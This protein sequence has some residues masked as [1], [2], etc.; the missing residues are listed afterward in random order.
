MT[1][2]C[3]KASWAFI[4]PC[5]ILAI[6]ASP[7]MAG[8][9]DPLDFAAVEQ[10]DPL[11]KPFIGSAQSGN[12][13]VVVGPRG[14]ILFSN[15][16][17][18]NWAQARVP[19]Q[20]DLVAVD[21]ASQSKGWAVGHDGV[22]LATTD[23][24]A[25]WIKQLDG[26]MA[27][28]QFVGYYRK[29]LEQGDSSVEAALELVELN[30]R[31]GPALPFLDV[32]FRDEMTG[33]AVGAFGS[34]VRTDD[35]GQS[36]MPWAHRI[37]NAEGA[38]LNSVV[39]IGEDVFIGSERGTLF[40]LNAELQSFD[41]LETGY[42]GTFTGVTGAGGVI[43]AY[44]LQGTIYRSTDR[45]DSWLE[46]AELPRATINDAF[47]RGGDQGYVLANQSGEL[48]VS[49]KRFAKFEVIDTGVSAN[50]TSVLEV[51]DQ[52]LLVTTLQGLAKVS[53]TDHRM[54]K[55]AAQE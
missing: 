27:G 26:R 30:Y 55:V 5:L 29:L 28:K 49:D 32:W 2:L 18:A 25:T 39:G 1:V 11:N 22:I 24:G 36:W 13:V 9:M 46:V 35:G 15:D 33:F 53:L 42:A 8:F 4:V 31:D 54:I 45:G 48:I 12:N 52:Q 6:L 23:G 51:A 37:A 44:G 47:L 16:A 10:K 43:V 50:F 41:M 17:G 20:S 3:K 38:H 40:R 19:V 21:M 34:I 14:L 7:S